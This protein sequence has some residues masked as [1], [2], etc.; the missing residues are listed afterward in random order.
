[1]VMRAIAGVQDA[2]T[3][4]EARDALLRYYYPLLRTLRRDDNDSAESLRSAHEWSTD[5]LHG[6]SKVSAALFAKSVCRHPQESNT[7]LMNDLQQAIEIAKHTPDTTPYQRVGLVLDWLKQERTQRPEMEWFHGGLRRWMEGL[8]TDFT[9]ADAKKR[10]GAM[11]ASP[12]SSYEHVVQSWA[13]AK[14]GLPFDHVWDLSG[15]LPP[16]GTQPLLG[17]MAQD[18]GQGHGTAVAFQLR[19]KLMQEQEPA[20]ALMLHTAIGVTRHYRPT[21]RDVT[22]YGVLHPLLT[23]DETSFDKNVWL[24]FL[25]NKG[26]KWRSP[27]NEKRWSTWQEAAQ[28]SYQQVLQTYCGSTPAALSSKGTGDNPLAFQSQTPLALDW[29]KLLT[30]LASRF[31]YLNESPQ[32]DTIARQRLAPEVFSKF[33]EES[34]ERVGQPLIHA[35]L[36][37]PHYLQELD[38]VNMP[39]WFHAGLQAV[40]AAQNALPLP[41]HLLDDDQTPGL[42]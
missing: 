5:L 9:L 33:V 29:Y 13:D 25:E 10:P 30:E 15:L 26:A 4:Q 19:A 16:K 38:A 35:L 18:G 1:M 32:L 36:E 17:L 40:M 3:F 12:E 31:P 6:T 41:E 42:C 11:L 27:E 24:D 28:T 39:A 37:L 20:M 21:W 23:L 14:S 34:K 22:D 7:S 8:L 2:T